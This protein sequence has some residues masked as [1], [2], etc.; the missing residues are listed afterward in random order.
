LEDHQ[1]SDHDKAVSGTRETLPAAMD[2]EMTYSHQ[3]ETQ[4][5]S[6]VSR[7]FHLDPLG[8]AGI[9]K[10]FRSDIFE[11]LKS[12]KFPSEVARLADVECSDGDFD[13]EDDG[14][15][16]EH[17]AAG[18]DRIRPG[19]NSPQIRY[20]TLS[21][22]TTRNNQK[23]F[24]DLFPNRFA[25]C[26]KRGKDGDWR[27]TSQFHHLSDEE[28]VESIEGRAPFLRACMAD[29][30]TRL[31]VVMIE[32]DSYYRTVEGLAKIRDCLQCIGINQLRLFVS[33]ETEQWQLFGFFSKPVG[34]TRISSLLSSWLRRNGIVPGTAG[35]SLFPGPDPFCFPLQKGFAWINDSGHTI[36]ARNEVSSEAALA[37]FIADMER[38]EIDGEELIERLDQ[39]LNQ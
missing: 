21:N 15:Q 36:V 30:E 16:A 11:K 39:V 7:T 27:E 33:D 20:E 8:D 26:I 19:I 10:G 6:I 3:V 31:V 2:G 4:I 29:R 9:A 37:L 24:L 34:S 35:V 23:I 32:R 22:V 13:V 18:E 12:V 14:D 17:P 1:Y 28:M 25:S 5:D 38:T